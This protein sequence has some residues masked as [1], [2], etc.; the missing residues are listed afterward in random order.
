MV[1]FCLSPYKGAV[2]ACICN[3]L[4]LK[5]IEKKRNDEKKYILF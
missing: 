2:R 4:D 5:K 3:P 1:L